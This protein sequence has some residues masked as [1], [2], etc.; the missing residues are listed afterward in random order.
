VKARP[1]PEPQAQ[2]QLP[3]EK[4]ADWT[5]LP[6]RDAESPSPASSPVAR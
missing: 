3:A 1:E 2:P 5:E 6:P 4:N